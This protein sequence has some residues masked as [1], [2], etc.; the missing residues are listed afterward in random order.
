M[1]KNFQPWAKINFSRQLNNKKVLG[2][3]FERINK[4][5]FL[6]IFL[7]IEFAL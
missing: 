4:L 7:E 6:F 1:T 3:G 2:T 5:F